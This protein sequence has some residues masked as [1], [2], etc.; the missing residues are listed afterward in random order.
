MRSARKCLASVTVL[1]LFGGILDPRV[2]RA[3]GDWESGASTSPRQSDAM[4]LIAQGQVQ[5]QDPEPTGSKSSSGVSKPKSDEIGKP[6]FLKHAFLFDPGSAK[7]GAESR[8][9]VKRAAT[10]LREHPGARILVVGFC[11]S[12]GS[13]TCTP[14]LA[15]RRGAVVGQCLVRLGVVPDQI[16]AVKGWSTADRECLTDTAKC[17]QVNRSAAIFIASSAEPLN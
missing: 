10:W 3:R 5:K 11:D 6:P 12:S 4:S 1:Y 7:L 8:G 17:Q 9:A 14:Y 2:P 16:A 13:E 15:E